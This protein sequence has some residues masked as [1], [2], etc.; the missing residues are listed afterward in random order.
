MSVNP[1]TSEKETRFDEDKIFEEIHVSQASLNCIIYMEGHLQF[2]KCSSKVNL[3]DRAVKASENDPQECL[4][5]PPFC[6]YTC[7]IRSQIKLAFHIC[8]I[9]RLGLDLV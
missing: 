3:L 5:S 9:H 6:C 7:L 8:R 4:Q 2:T 1:K